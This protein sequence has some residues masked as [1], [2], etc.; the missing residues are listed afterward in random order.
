MLRRGEVSVEYA[1]MLAFIVIVILSGIYIV[2]SNTHE[3]W[4]E[5]MKQFNSAMQK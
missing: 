4:Q 5:N 3:M 2:G 1:M